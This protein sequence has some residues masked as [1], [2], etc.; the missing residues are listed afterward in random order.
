MKKYEKAEFAMTESVETIGI[1]R[2]GGFGST[3]V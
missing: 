1:N 2:E 3:G